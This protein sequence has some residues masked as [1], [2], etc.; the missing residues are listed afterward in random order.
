[1]AKKT[2]KPSNDVFTGLLGL[3]TLVVLGTAVYV[4]M[5]CWQYYDT[6]FKI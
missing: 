3:S 5:M 4:G 6:L 1:M 2:I